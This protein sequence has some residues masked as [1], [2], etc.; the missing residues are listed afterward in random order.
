[1]KRLAALG[2]FAL[3]AGMPLWAQDH[4]AAAAGTPD[5]AE[6]ERIQ[7]RRERES[8]SF[9]AQEADCYQHFAVSACVNNVQTKRRA[10]LAELRREEALLHERESAQRGAEQLRLTAQKARDR[11]QQDV[12]SSAQSA[13]DTLADRLQTQQDKRQAHASKAAAS[14]AAQGR[15]VPAASG[16]SAAE[17]ASNRENYA[18]KQ[19]EAER[20]RQDIAR[21]LADRKSK[22][23]APL[24]VP[25]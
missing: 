14:A 23:A 13:A 3:C 21:R 18:R 9:D 25:Q 24:P 4:V 7:A 1:M 17:Q 8:A 15:T 16:P 11:L 5:A 20:K 6:F 22:P 2:L 10:V 19:A 12:G